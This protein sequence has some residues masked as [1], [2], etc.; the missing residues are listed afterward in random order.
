[1]TRGSGFER[2][3]RHRDAEEFQDD[4]RGRDEAQSS[5]RSETARGDVR[6]V[7]ARRRRGA[8]RH[9]APEVSGCPSAP[10]AMGGRVPGAP[11]PARTRARHGEALVQPVGEVVAVVAVV[12]EVDD[13]PAHARCLQV[14]R[15]PRRRVAARAVAI[16][17]D[18]DIP[19]LEEVCPFGLPGV[20]SGDGDRGQPLRA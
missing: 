14:A 13:A 16:E 5:A 8:G 11:S 2:P 20:V 3:H 15:D 18:R 17:H 10:G 4:G 19:A 9:S 7:S 12:R 6:A 1:M